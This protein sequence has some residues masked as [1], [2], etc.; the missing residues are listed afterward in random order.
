MRFPT[1]GDHGDQPEPITY[2][3]F[4]RPLQEQ[5]LAP[6]QIL[7]ASAARIQLVVVSSAVVL[8]AS[9]ALE[10]RRRCFS[11]LELSMASMSKRFL[12]LSCR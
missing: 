7:A 1:L 6:Q 10:V 8:L 9:E 11:P 5:D 12:R 3:K 4:V 2:S